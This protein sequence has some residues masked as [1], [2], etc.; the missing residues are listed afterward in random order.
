MHYSLLVITNSFPTDEILTEILQPY[1]EF[2]CT[3]IEDEYVQDVDITDEARKEFANATTRMIRMPDGQ[4]I[5]RYDDQFYRDLTDEEKTKLTPIYLLGRTSKDWGD[6]QGYRAK[7]HFIPEGATEEEVPTSSLKT[8][9]EFITYWYGYSACTT[10]PQ[11]GYRYVLIDDDNNVVK[12]IDR[13][14]PNSKWDWWVVGGRWSNRLRTHQQEWVNQLQVKNLDLPVM[15]TAARTYRE[16]ALRDIQYG[17]GLDYEEFMDHLYKTIHEYRK[18]K[19]RTNLITD[20][21]I[22]GFP[23]DEDISVHQWI[24]DAPALSYYAY[25]MDGEWVEEEELDLEA[26]DPDLYITMVDYHV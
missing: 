10:P 5:D 15:K 13:T 23:V 17:L 1:H 6:G 20:L 21:Q 12:V 14:N 9:L 3:G 4:L 16:E 8:E 22:A 7:V 25:L 26:L 11:S 24:Q 19:T 18:D 2:E